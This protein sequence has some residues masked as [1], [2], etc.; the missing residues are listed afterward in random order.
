M[1]VSQAARRG[2]PPALSGQ[3]TDAFDASV[4]PFVKS[5]AGADAGGRGDARLRTA[6]EMKRATH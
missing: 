5:G 3:V 2:S 6:G 1:V 4:S